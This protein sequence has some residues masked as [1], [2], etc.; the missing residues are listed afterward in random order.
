MNRLP[1]MA[2]GRIIR[3]MP[4]RLNEQTPSNGY[5]EN[6]TQYASSTEWTDSL[7]WLLG[8]SY[9]VCLVDWM[10]RLPQMAI[11]RII[12]SMPR[13][14]NE[15]TPSKWPFGESHAV[16]L[17][18]WMK[19]LPQMA[20]G[21]IIRSMPRRLNEETPSNGHW[22]NHT[23]YASS[24]EWTDSIKRPLGES[25]AVCLVDWMKQTPSNGHWENHT[26]T[27]WRDSIKRPLGES[28]AVC[29]VDWMNRLPQMA[30]GRISRSMPRRLNEE[31]PS[32]GHWE[33]HTQYA[34][35]TEWTDSIKRPLGESYAVCLVDWMKRTPSNG[36]WENHTQY[37]S[38]TEWTDSIKRP[39]GESYVDWMNRLHQTAIGRI[40]RRLNECLT[41]LWWYHSLPNKMSTFNFHFWLQSLVVIKPTVKLNYRLEWC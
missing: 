21:R 33:N 4:R 10:N 8:E 22:E 12:R 13:R 39:L 16:C 3:S 1:Q 14:L 7:K 20:I 36:H 40:I 6:H 23:Q 28:Y 27:E 32:N 18:D 17:V 30:I 15:Q 29:L 11:G 37:A 5:W 2:I 34:S 31:T 41:N 38:S 24:T 35:S 25:Y 19:R 26:S 9:A